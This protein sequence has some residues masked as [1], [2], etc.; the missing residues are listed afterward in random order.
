LLYACLT[1]G[2]KPISCDDPEADCPDFGTTQPDGTANFYKGNSPDTV[3]WIPCLGGN[4]GCS[5]TD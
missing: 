5:S 2:L 4:C 3:C 1:G